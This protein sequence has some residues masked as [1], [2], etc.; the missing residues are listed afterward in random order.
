MRKT[1]RRWRRSGQRMRNNSLKRISVL[2][3][4]KVI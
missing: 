1:R 2:H 3:F 4:E